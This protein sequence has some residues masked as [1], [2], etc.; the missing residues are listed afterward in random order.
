[1]SKR[2]KTPEALGRLIQDDGREDRIYR[3]RVDLMGKARAARDAKRAARRKAVADEH[4]LWKRLNLPRSQ[5]G[6]NAQRQIGAKPGWVLLWERMEPGAWYAD[7]DLVALMPEY[8]Y[9]SP[10]AWLHQKLRKRGMV[11][12][13]AKQRPDSLFRRNGEPEFLYRRIG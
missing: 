7:E 6:P 10:R 5:S 8:A 1:M 4:R 12:R 9:G 13:A 2:K 3:K 11:E